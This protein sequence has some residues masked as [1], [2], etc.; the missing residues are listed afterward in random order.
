MTDSRSAFEANFQLSSRQAKRDNAGEYIDE[1]VRA[2]WEGW[3]AARGLMEKDTARLDWLEAMNDVP[4]KQFS[5]LGF[6][7]IL[8]ARDNGW[9][10]DREFGGTWHQTLRKAIDAAAAYAGK[11]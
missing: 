9:R 3:Q 7:S 4:G 11:S 2:K 5:S 6:A 10:V 1:F 8:P